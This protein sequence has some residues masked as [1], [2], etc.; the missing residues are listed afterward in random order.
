MNKRI[1]YIF[2]FV[3]I[4]LI[5]AF[6]NT[7]TVLVDVYIDTQIKT[8]TVSEGEFFQEPD[9]PVKDG[10][11]FLGWYTDSAF[12]VPYDFSTPVVQNTAVYALFSAYPLGDENYIA[13]EE[14]DLWGFMTPTGEVI[15]EAI[16]DLVEPFRYGLAM[17]V[18]DNQFTFINTL[19]VENPIW[20]DYSPIYYNGIISFTEDGYSRILVDSE[21]IIVNFDLETVF[22]TAAHFT[23]E[24]YFNNGYAPVNLLDEE[25][26][27]TKYCGYI[28]IAG[29]V[30]GSIENQ[31][32]DCTPFNEGYAFIEEENSGYYL[33]NSDIEKVHTNAYDFVIPMF[34][35]MKSSY[36]VD[37]RAIVHITTETDAYYA[38]IDFLGNELVTF[39]TE[40]VMFANDTRIVTRNSDWKLAIYD[41]AGNVISNYL[42]YSGSSPIGI[43]DGLIIVRN[44]FNQYGAMND[45]GELVI[46]LVYEA[47]SPFSDGYAVAKEEGLYGVINQANEIVV[48]F[49]YDT[50]TSRYQYFMIYPY[51]Q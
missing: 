25:Q 51:I 3:F 20:F 24:S 33:I 42:Y 31:Y 49:S 41:Y 15:V 47:L 30:I 2:I 5:I 26:N 21:S 17:V 46:P 34:D 14:N 35:G 50:L 16:Y 8:Y 36:V 22:S 27:V 7:K 9:Y 19:G 37:G 48:D 13:F 23:T 32:T 43:Y 1:Y 29:N 6:N 18:K 12:T 44:G 38:V 45:D 4:F 40:I 11:L 10:Y 39:S 28:D